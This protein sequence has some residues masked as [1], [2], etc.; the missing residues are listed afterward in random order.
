MADAPMKLPIKEVA[1]RGEE[2]YHRVVRPAV[3]E[4]Y[5]GKVVVIDIHS[6]DYAI[7]KNAVEVSEHELRG[8]SAAD[9]VSRGDLVS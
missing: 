5:R 7:G 8:R 2:I 4:T 9:L 1:Q 3:N 6:G